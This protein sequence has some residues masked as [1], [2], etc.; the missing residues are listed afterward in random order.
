ML[1]APRER[2]CLVV[3]YEDGQRS[4]RCQQCDHAQRYGCVE[5]ELLH[6]LQPLPRVVERLQE[7][8]ERKDGLVGIDAGNHRQ[9]GG[10][11]EGRH[12]AAD[13][14]PQP[15]AARPGAFRG[16]LPP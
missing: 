9:Q 14:A 3:E 8:D 7:H 12:R 16:H 15:P 4:P 1:A 13:A 10:D 5:E 2:E 6:V 11:V